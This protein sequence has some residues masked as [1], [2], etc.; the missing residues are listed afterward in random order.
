MPIAR[1]RSTG[2]ASMIISRTFV[3]TS[4]VMMTPSRTIT[5]M[6]SGQDRPSWPTSV[7]ATNP[8][9]PSPAASANG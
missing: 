2:I 4:T 3:S 7:K 1:F 6:A 8:L 5:P 9:S